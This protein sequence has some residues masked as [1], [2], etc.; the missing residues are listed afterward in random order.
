MEQTDIETASIAEQRDNAT[1]AAIQR[2]LH[3]LRQFMRA[4][5][6]RADAEMPEHDLV[7]VAGIDGSSPDKTIMDAIS[8]RPELWAHAL[9][10][11]VCIVPRE[12]LEKLTGPDAADIIDATGKNLVLRHALRA[13][14]TDSS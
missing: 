12:Q 2:L 1:H 7:W 14:F 8:K 13:R 10:D 5:P 3:N 6:M 11:D 9:P 4:Y